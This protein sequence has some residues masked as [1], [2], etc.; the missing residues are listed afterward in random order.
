[1]RNVSTPRSRENLELEVAIGKGAFSVARERFETV[2]RSTATLSRHM[3][4]RR[5][6]QH[7][8]RA[9]L[10]TLRNTLS[11]ESRRDA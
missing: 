3:Q 6:I 8:L 9:V 10:Q 1:M 7:D 2:S 5:E 4:A 11:D